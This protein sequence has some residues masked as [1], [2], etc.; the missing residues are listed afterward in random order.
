M[1]QNVAATTHLASFSLS[2]YFH[3]KFLF[4]FSF[5]F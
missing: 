3:L 2:F 4:C 5:R 1:G